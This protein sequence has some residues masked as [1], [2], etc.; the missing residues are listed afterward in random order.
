MAG[1]DAR[2]TNGGIPP[3]NWAPAIDNLS[4]SKE[5]SPQASRAAGEVT[6]FACARVSSKPLPNASPLPNPPLGQGEGIN[7]VCGVL[8]LI[9]WWGGPP[10]PPSVARACARATVRS[11]N[12]H[13]AFS[14]G[15]PESLLILSSGSIV[16]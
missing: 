15:M 10:R 11:Q 1:R 9:S 13:Q 7:E 4:L 3:H 16:I 6:R 5:R 8:Q 12:L 2:P 14:V